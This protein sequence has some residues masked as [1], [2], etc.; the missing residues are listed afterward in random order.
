MRH[1]GMQSILSDD[2]TVLM[3]N[4]SSK[5][6]LSRIDAAANIQIF[7]L[8]QKF[9]LSNHVGHN[10]AV[11]KD[12]LRLAEYIRNQCKS[13]QRTE[14]DHRSIGVIFP[15]KVDRQSDSGHHVG[16]SMVMDS[17]RPPF[18]DTNVSTSFTDYFDTFD[19]VLKK[20]EII[21]SPLKQ[22]EIIAA[23]T[24]R[25]DT[26]P[27]EEFLS[28]TKVPGISPG[29]SRL[30]SKILS[31]SKLD[32][33]ISKSISC[34]DPI[35]SPPTAAILPLSLIPEIKRADQISEQFRIQDSSIPTA[36]GCNPN[37]HCDF[38]QHRHDNDKVI[39]ENAH[40][41]EIYNDASIRLSDKM[42]DGDDDSV[43]DL[44]QSVDDWSAL[45]NFVQE[46]HSPA[47]NFIKQLDRDFE[48][49]G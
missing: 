21:S 34:I 13:L 44:L 30:L 31:P 15:S 10:D 39:F 19:A 24:S 12:I 48:N 7:L 23:A 6:A 43:F 3:M 29:F 11:M 26:T 33:N 17:V 49:P 14:E 32:S 2:S 37:S 42:Y 27:V 5:I 25:D 4:S 38:D 22:I 8:Q 16:H 9:Q 35:R 1:N 41:S 28:P 40:R 47:E 18:S 20:E 45:Q 36:T 46:N